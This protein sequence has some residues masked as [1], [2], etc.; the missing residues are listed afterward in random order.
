MLKLNKEKKNRN[1]K[2]NLLADS[3]CILASANLF[4]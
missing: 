3:D 4:V 2:I 1:T